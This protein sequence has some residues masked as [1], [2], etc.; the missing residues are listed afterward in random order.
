M[1]RVLCLLLLFHHFLETLLELGFFIR[2][3]AFLVFLQLPVNGVLAIIGE[4]DADWKTLLKAHESK[5]T[6]GTTPK[7]EVQQASVQG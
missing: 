6:A 3:R 7:Q 1:R 2:T 5:G 4:K